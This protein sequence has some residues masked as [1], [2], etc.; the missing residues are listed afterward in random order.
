M[1]DT[2]NVPR[3]DE[4][5]DPALR[6]WVESANDGVT[7]FPIQNL[8]FGVFR[9]AE[10]ETPRIGI[11]IGDQI[12]DCSA[13]LREGLFGTLPAELHAALG[14][15]LL[16]HLLATGR[17]G[18]RAVRRAAS[19]LLRR[20]GMEAERAGAAHQRLL[21]PMHAAT[22]LLPAAIGDYTDFYASIHHAT[23]IG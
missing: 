5:H 13:A 6:S 22:M 23:N 21:V 12:L 9:S 15:S 20:G 3:L 19:R 16:N 1:T 7:D 17:E 4:T 10:E 2:T 14:A 18:A 8:P 11:A